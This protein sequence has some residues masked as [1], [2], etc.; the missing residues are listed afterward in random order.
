MTTS[1]IGV[2]ATR[3]PLCAKA[4]TRSR[5]DINPT[6]LPRSVTISAAIRFRIINAAAA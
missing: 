4:P 2:P 6:G 1:R 3:D 5:S